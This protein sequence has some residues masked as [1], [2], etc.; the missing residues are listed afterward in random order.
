MGLFERQEEALGCYF[1]VMLGVDLDA[2]FSSV[3]GLSYEL[4]METYQEGGNN[5]GPHF[6]PVSL[7]PQRLILEGGIMSPMQMALWLRAA[8]LGT[9]P[10]VMG[11]IMLCNEKGEPIQ[12]W[13][14]LDA[15]PVKYEGPILEATESK[16]AIA[17]IEIMHN[18]L[19]P[20][21]LPGLP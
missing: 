3:R 12:S 5:A 7:I 9:F 6:F 17:S 2:N 18:G 15:Y 13:T 20:G 10:R 16:I 21:L 1:R 19:L 8:E 14:M 4:E 11:M